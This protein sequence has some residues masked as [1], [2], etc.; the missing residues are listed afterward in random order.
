M[1]LTGGDMSIKDK[2]GNL[3]AKI[4]GKVL[5]V[6][7]RCVVH[8]ANGQPACCIIQKILSMSHSYFVYSYKP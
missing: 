4:D 6:R 3:I 7:D 8:G 2:E 5:S 1:T